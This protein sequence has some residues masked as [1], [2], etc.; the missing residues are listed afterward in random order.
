ML[1]FLQLDCNLSE[2]FEPYNE[3][4]ATN[5]IGP[6]EV[7]QVLKMITTYLIIISQRLQRCSYA[8]YFKNIIEDLKF[9]IISSQ[10][11]SLLRPYQHDLM[12]R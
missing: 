2:L 4:K 3:F 8:L 6:L 5:S 9:A 11:E 7:I 10:W 12:V 1:I